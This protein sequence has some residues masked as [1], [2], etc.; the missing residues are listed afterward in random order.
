MKGQEVNHSCLCRLGLPMFAACLCSYAFKGKVR[1]RHQQVLIFIAPSGYAE[2]GFPL[3]LEGWP[4][5][6]LLPGIASDLPKAKI[7]SFDE[8]QIGL[9]QYESVV[10]ALEDCRKA[11]PGFHL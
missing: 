9:L 3:L 6:G 10:A 2:W 8:T 7:H 4:G 1:H 11:T 5:R